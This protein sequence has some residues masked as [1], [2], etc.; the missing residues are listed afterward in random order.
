M[1]GSRPLKATRPAFLMHR[2][3]VSA[4]LF[5]IA[6]VAGRVPATA[7][8]QNATLNA[9][10]NGLARLSLSTAAITFPDA[11]PDTVPSIQ[12]AQGPIT[13]TAKARTSPNGT[14]TLTLMAN[15]VLRSGINTIP[16]SNI[17]WTATGAGFS[18]G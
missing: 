18:N 9:S 8:T 10:I 5:V 7:Q 4:I 16:A 14:V 13:V 15:D 12:A 11:D 1:R 2:Q 3:T 6:F 17:T